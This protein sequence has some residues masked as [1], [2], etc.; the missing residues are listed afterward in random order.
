MKGNAPQQRCFVRVNGATTMLYHTRQKTPIIRSQSLTFVHAC[1][2]CNG[3][4]SRF[5]SGGSC[6]GYP[7]LIYRAIL[8]YRDR[9]LALHTVPNMPSRP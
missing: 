4:E 2:L 3:M 6:S 1:Y 8:Q 9:M 7:A 5:L